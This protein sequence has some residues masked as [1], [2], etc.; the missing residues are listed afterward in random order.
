[1]FFAMAGGSCLCSRI[2]DIR[3]LRPHSGNVANVEPNQEPA[4][5]SAVVFRGSKI[6]CHEFSLVLEAKGMEHE[7]KESE[8]SWVL[9]VPLAGLGRAYD[10]I[11][12]YAA[13]R[14]VPRTLPDAI[15][16]RPGAS[17]GAVAYVAILLLTAYC[18]GNEWFG[19][20]WLAIGDLQAG[21]AGEWWR[22]VTAL[23][24]HL[25]QEH[26]LGNL[27]FGVIAGVAAA[28]LL[29]DGVAWASILGAA[30]LANYMEILIAPVTHRAVGAS[31]AVFAA[32]GLVAGMAWRQRLTRRERLWYRWAPLIAGICLLTLLGAGSAHVD[33]LGHA[34]GF[35]FGIGVGWTYARLGVPNNRSRRLQIIAGAG[36]ALLVC[37]AWLM[38]LSH[39][40]AV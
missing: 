38:A 31:T 39:R 2:V 33:V 18:A 40:A 6:L 26:L 9:T 11:A 23:T 19:A 29:G 10:E 30:V 4:Q 25:D 15:P 24:L 21:A 14:S 34:L 27:L 22:A 13:E 3:V 16:V 1:M 12:R 37:V 17:I 36:A 5:G 20:D 8:N 35:I 32:L 7:T 28:R